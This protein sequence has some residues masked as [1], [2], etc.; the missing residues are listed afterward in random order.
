MAGEGVPGG[1]WVGKGG[2]D[3]LFIYLFNN[4]VLTGTT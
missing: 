2:K 1:G 4:D 3:D